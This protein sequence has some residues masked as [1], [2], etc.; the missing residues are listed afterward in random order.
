VRGG[1]RY[2]PSVDGSF[3]V[4]EDGASEKGSAAVSEVDGSHQGVALRVDVSQRLRVEDLARCLTDRRQESGVD[5][6]AIPV[7]EGREAGG[8]VGG[9]VDAAD[10]LTIDENV[11][12]GTGLAGV[13]D[14]ICGCHYCVGE[15]VGESVVVVRV[16][17]LWWW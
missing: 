2:L 6:G 16:L 7:G 14:K 9:E 1:I 12:K 13:A 4:V 5:G 3:V 11:A 17:C 8:V 10:L 15:S